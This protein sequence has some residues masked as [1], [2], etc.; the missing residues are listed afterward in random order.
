MIIA[1]LRKL[2][3]LL[4]L[5]IGQAYADPI[6]DIYQ[7][8]MIIFE[9]TD[10]KRFSGEDWPKI[11]GNLDYAQAIN[12]DD[13]KTNIPESIETLDVLDSLDEAGEKPVKDIVKGTINIVDS[14]HFL[15]KR[16]IQTIRS[17]KSQRFIKHIA[18]NQPLAVNVKSTPVYFTAGKDQEV[19]ALILIKPVRNIFN[20]SLDVIYKIQPQDR[21][22]HAE[23]NEIRVT[24]DAR[25][26]KKEVYYI[27]HP[28]I[29]IILIVSPVLYG[30][31]S[32]APLPNM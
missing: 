19:A 8:E 32:Y 31:N 9:H 1:T 6:V 21:K 15:L 12:L 11:V 26:K 17:S 29:G 10:P 5:A 23:I 2:T 27:D 13:L 28:V 24:K 4:V 3:F 14:Q 22:D 18:W 25:V 16:E 20:V 30:A 7:V